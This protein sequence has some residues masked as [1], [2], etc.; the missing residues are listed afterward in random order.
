MPHNFEIQ[1]IKLPKRYDRRYTITQKQKDDVIQLR[2][3]GY[4]YYEIAKKVK[5]SRHSVMFILKPDFYTKRL[6]Y[7][8]D[9]YYRYKDK[10]TKTQKARNMLSYRHYKMEVVN[11]LGLK[12]RDIIKTKTTTKNMIKI[13]LKNGTIIEME[14][15]DKEVFKDLHFNA[16]GNTKALVTGMLNGYFCKVCKKELEGHCRITCKA[17]SCLD[18]YG[19]VYQRNWSRKKR[20]RLKNLEIEKLSAENP[21]LQETNPFEVAIKEII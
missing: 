5:I 7:Y 8:V 1:H 17:K 19:R 9:N 4:F 18:K 13:I 10:K 16:T 12:G 15:Y 21:S 20:E 14:N 3:A 2:Q 11:K 6:Q